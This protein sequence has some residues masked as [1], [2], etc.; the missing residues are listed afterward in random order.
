MS[1]PINQGAE[2][3]KIAKITHL[4]EDGRAQVVVEIRV[5]IVDADGINP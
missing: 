3:T 5:Q 2:I 1:V 4:V